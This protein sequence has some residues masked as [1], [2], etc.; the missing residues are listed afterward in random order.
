MEN[1]RRGVTGPILNA[2]IE[3]ID[4]SAIG[5]YVLTVDQY[6]FTGIALL[7][8]VAGMVSCCET[9]SMLIAAGIILSIIIIPIIIGIVSIICFLILVMIITH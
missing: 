1:V 7:S 2:I 3:Y 6:R 5:Q 9:S 8:V 4:R